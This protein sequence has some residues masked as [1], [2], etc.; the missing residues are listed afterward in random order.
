MRVAC[1]AG[2]NI[3]VSRA[4]IHHHATVAGCWTMLSHSGRSNSKQ[5]QV[6]VLWLVLHL[7]FNVLL[8]CCT[9]GGKHCV[10]LRHDPACADY[11]LCSCTL[12]P[13][14]GMED[15]ETIDC[16]MQQVGGRC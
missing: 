15:G 6:C 12:L 10:A 8:P 14:L 5:S 3:V 1:H 11:A 4:V 9:Q 2:A 7:C 13:Q 16:F